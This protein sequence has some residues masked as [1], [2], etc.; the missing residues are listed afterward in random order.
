MP[1]VEHEN[2]LRTAA[3]LQQSGQEF[4]LITVVRTQGSTPRN[5]GAKMLWRPSGVQSPNG[6][7]GTVGGGHFEQLVVE[8]ARVCCEKRSHALEKFVLGSDADQCCGGVME[9]F[10][11]Y[12]GAP[13]H[14]V[15]FGAGHVAH[16]LCACL[17]FSSLSITVVDDRAD[18]CSATR[19]PGAACVHSWEDGIAAAHRRRATTLTVVM[20]CSHETDFELLRALLANPPAFTG[21]IGSRSKRACLFT[22]LTASG[23]EATALKRI[24]CPIGVGDTGKEPMA[25]AISVAA[26]LLMEAKALAN[27]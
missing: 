18:W 10:L 4:V 16:A 19:F 7:V 14:L 12:H 25:V 6:A 5:A 27:A 3:E 20:T 26:Q 24:V 11:E 15:I 8:A 2:V 23:V 21:L 9:V 1:M 13:A 22:R 17:A